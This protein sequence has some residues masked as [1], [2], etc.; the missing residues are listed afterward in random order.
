M[1]TKAV[2]QYSES[3]IKRLLE[4][5]ANV[6]VDLV[7]NNKYQIIAT[8]TAIISCCQAGLHK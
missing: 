5:K 8:K 6:D 2:N 4:I 1:Y 7:K 3:E